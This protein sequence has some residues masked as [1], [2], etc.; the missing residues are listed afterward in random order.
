MGHQY[1]S[2]AENGINSTTNWFKPLRLGQFY[3]VASFAVEGIGLILPIRAT[4][5]DY[6]SF[7]WLFHVIG[8][9]IVVWYF[10]FGMSGA[11]RFGDKT[12]GIILFAYSKSFQ[13]VYTIT[14]FYAIVERSY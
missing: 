10:F 7:R 14:F 3:G 5:Q 1:V 8:G 4:M 6:K 13:F 2:V 9:C 12:P 11:M